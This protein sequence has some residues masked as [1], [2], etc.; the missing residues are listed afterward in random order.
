MVVLI[1][2]TTELGVGEFFTDLLTDLSRFCVCLS[3]VLPGWNFLC[4]RYAV[5]VKVTLTLNPQILA[6]ASSPAALYVM[7]LVIWL[8]YPKFEASK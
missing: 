2:G 1:S 8:N 3:Y 6:K 5:S 7:H 4:E